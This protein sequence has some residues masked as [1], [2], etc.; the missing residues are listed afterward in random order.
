M[1]LLNRSNVY[2]NPYP[3]SVLPIIHGAAGYV[4]NNGFN[5]SP[6]QPGFQLFATTA[7]TVSAAPADGST[8]I[9]QDIRGTVYTFE[10]VY[11]GSSPTPGDIE[12]ALPA[13]GGTAAQSHDALIA[14]IN[15]VVGRPFIAS[16]TGATQGIIQQNEAGPFA[17]SP[18]IGGTQAT[19]TFSPTNAFSNPENH[20]GVIPGFHG[21]FSW[22]PTNSASE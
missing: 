2:Q 6:Y 21:I 14:A 7:F 15:N 19:F 4:P 20:T 10:F 8:L 17:G 12:V 13:L 16:S 9:F 1:G 22:L 5:K 3:V 11:S 18:N